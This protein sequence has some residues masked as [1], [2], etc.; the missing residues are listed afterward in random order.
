MLVS[1]VPSW[2]MPGCTVIRT[3]LSHELMSDC[4]PGKY[5]EG[6]EVAR[7]LG[8][9][10]APLWNAVASSWLSVRVCCLKAKHMK[11]KSCLEE[12]GVRSPGLSAEQPEPGR[13]TSPA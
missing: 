6:V 3:C 12:A 1:A 5:G 2:S 10:S 7:W 13:Q 8:K 11:V 9:P 4:C